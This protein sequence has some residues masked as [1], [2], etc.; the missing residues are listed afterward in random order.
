MNVIVIALWSIFLLKI[1]QKMCMQYLL[2]VLSPS[3]FKDMPYGKFFNFDILTNI[4]NSL[5][6]IY[7]HNDQLTFNFGDIS[8]TNSCRLINDLL[9]ITATL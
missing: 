9:Q 4:L 7:L 2:F 1:S 5:A 3:G 8:L 6:A